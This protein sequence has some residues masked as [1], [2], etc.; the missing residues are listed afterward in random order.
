MSCVAQKR[1]YPDYVPLA[2]PLS[3]TLEPQFPKS[4]R[5]S[6]LTP[7]SQ[8][9]LQMLFIFASTFGSSARISAS[10]GIEG[11]GVTVPSIRLLGVPFRS[12][13]MPVVDS[14]AAEPG[15][16]VEFAVPNVLVPGA[17]G[18]FSELPAPL[19]S[20]P[21]LFRPPALAGPLGTPL[22]AAVPAPGDP[23]FGEPTEL[24]VPMLGPLAAPADDVPPADPPPLLC[25]R[26]NEAANENA[27]A[28][29]ITVVF[30]W[31][32]LL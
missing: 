22:T 32:P 7:V 25:A 28:N 16:P 19:G 26:A 5:W 24:P 31:C 23:A 2:R 1:R 15:D 29:A 4:D 9:P 18:A 14:L 8:Q 20:L 21:E 3:G 30:I 27:V 13:A 10:P 12:C 11:P 6:A 17:V